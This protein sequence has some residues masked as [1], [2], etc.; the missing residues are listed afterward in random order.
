VTLA[1]FNLLGKQI[2]VLA[3]GQHMA[4]LHTVSWDGRDENG[5]MMGSGIYFYK[6]DTGENVYTKKM[7]IIR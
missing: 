1:V 3:E 6:L 5:Q 4:G 2:R 7:T